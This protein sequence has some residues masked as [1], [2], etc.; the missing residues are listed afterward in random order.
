MLRSPALEYVLEK[1][2]T[3]LP[4][5][6]PSVLTMVTVVGSGERSS[7]TMLSDSVVQWVESG[8]VVPL[9]WYLLDHSFVDPRYEK[10]LVTLI[11]AAEATSATLATE[12][13][14]CTLAYGSKSGAFPRR[15]R[16]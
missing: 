15:G 5:A 14:G 9:K 2:G 4:G 3:S 16:A 6:K 12:S 11:E 8:G 10:L 1:T 7:P 13:D